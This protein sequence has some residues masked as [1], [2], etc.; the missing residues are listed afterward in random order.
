MLPQYDLVAELAADRARNY[1][2]T[3]AG[4]RGRSH[5]RIRH[6][7]AAI[8]RHVADRLDPLPGALVA[9]GR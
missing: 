6:A 2:R 7:A 1:R 4:M 3:A 9:S 8:F 5:G